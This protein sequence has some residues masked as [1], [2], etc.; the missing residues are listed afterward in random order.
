MDV[1]EQFKRL[2]AYS[3]HVSNINTD[4]DF[5][6][7]IKVMHNVEPDEN[8]IRHYLYEY[9][10]AFDALHLWLPGD[11]VDDIMM[12]INSQDRFEDMESLAK[13]GQ[14]AQALLNASKTEVIYYS[15]YY[16]CWNQLTVY[17]LVRK[18]DAMWRRS[19]R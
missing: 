15:T 3:K 9:Q 8:A 1:K 17:N 13:V 5:A 18:I 4:F 16:E 14:Q 19:D 12:D 7:F 11:L 2:K 6:D 10:A